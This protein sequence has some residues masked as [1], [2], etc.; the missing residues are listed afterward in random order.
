VPALLIS[1]RRGGG[2]VLGFQQ[3]VSGLLLC[4]LCCCTLQERIR[5]IR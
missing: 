3:G 2:G 5:I 1:S 4:S